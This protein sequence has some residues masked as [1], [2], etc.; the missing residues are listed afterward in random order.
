MSSIHHGFFRYQTYYSHKFFKIFRGDYCCLALKSIFFL[1][2]AI[3]IEKKSKKLNAKKRLGFIYHWIGWQ[4]QLY[5]GRWRKQGL[6]VPVNA[7]FQVFPFQLF[8][9][10]QRPF[11]H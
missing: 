3:F 8:W 6:V 7:A 10:L 1:I 5:L 9:M 11:S 4:P 2:Q